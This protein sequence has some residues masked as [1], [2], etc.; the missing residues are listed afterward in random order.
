MKFRLSDDLLRYHFLVTAL[1]FV[2][3]FLLVKLPPGLTYDEA[4]YVSAGI[5]LA[6]DGV[7]LNREH[8]MFAKE[9]LSL[10][11]FV[12]GDN[13]YIFR[14][15]SLVVAST[16]FFLAARALWIFTG[17]RNA[18][19]AFPLLLVC[20]ALLP[21]LARLAQLE[22]FVFGF[23]ALT[24]YL[25]VKGH[26][27]LS[28]VALGLAVA[29]KWSVAPLALA[30]E[31]ALLLRR[32]WR[33]A[34]IVPL[35]SAVTYLAT[36]TPAFF[37]S[38]DAISPLDLPAMHLVMQKSLAILAGTPQY[39]SNWWDWLYGG[40]AV[41]DKQGAIPVALNPVIAVASSVA[42]LRFRSVPVSLTGLSFLALIIMSGKQG[43]M[44]HLFLLPHVFFVAALSLEVGRLPPK[45]FYTSL[46]A[47]IAS[48]A[49][50]PLMVR[51]HEGNSD[52]GPNDNAGS[53]ADCLAR[54]RECDL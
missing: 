5:N 26:T 39:E 17:D 22:A 25:F 52:F 19:V 40:G 49:L 8:P 3:C 4:Y 53:M 13:L 14:L 41:W 2:L 12:A 27:R 42:I 45:V 38:V 32:D 35:I 50:M 16:G 9:L 10:V 43:L 29:C 37:A 15:A 28:G 30:I 36:F 46:A 23:S 7:W 21:G 6:R 34:L 44:I 51:Y 47:A 20:G 1:F 24:V 11:W 31:I 54:P 18:A 48:L 33:N